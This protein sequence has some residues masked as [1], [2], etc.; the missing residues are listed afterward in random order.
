M[1]DEIIIIIIIIIIITNSEI[2][3]VQKYSEYLMKRKNGSNEN[4][5]QN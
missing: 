2:F 4:N 3:S 5:N 1:T